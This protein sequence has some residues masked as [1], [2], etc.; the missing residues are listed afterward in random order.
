MTRKTV[1][2]KEEGLDGREWRKK[3]KLCYSS[4]ACVLVATIKRKKK[5]EK[6]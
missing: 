6:E 1:S 3:T 5:R 4:S 2:K